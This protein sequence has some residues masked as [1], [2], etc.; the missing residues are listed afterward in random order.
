MTQFTECLNDTWDYFFLAD[1]INLLKFQ[2]ENN[3]SHDLI[4]E[5]TANDSGELAA[6]KGIIIPLS[7]VNN[8]PY[9]IFFQVNSELS[10][11]NDKKNDLQFKK[12]GYLLEVTNNEIYLITIPYLKN[13]TKDTGLQNLISN[14]I[15]PKVQLENGLY[16]VTILGGDTFQESGWEPTL[17]FVLNKEKDIQFN[18]EDLNFM[19]SVSSK[20]Y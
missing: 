12:P 13:W 4:S 15:R 10:V 9:N 20:D 3:L 19:F 6:E 18:V 11:F 17:E 14:G 5:F 8:Y 2:E 1:P 7:G 16:S